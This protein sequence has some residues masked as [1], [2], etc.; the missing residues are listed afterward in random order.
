MHVIRRLRREADQG[1]TLIELLVVIVLLG[2]VGSIVMGSLM[3]AMKSTRQHQNR[4][5][6]TEDV[7]TQVE[8]M[9]R[10]IRVADP[11]RA[12]SA[13][14]MTVDLYRGTSCV[15]QQWSISG[16]TLQVTATTYSTWAA[17]SKYPA[18]VA[19]V[20]TTTRAALTDL[21]NPAATIFTYENSSGATLTNPAV[22][23][24]AVVHITLSKKVGE[25]STSVSFSTSVGVRNESL[26]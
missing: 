9:A 6:S 7:Q 10:D 14:S 2:V 15:R 5:Y 25:K 17:C 13:T 12:A 26:A 21:T 24:I 4:T 18:T 1:Y 22:S 20:S 11:I 19:A 8:R 16:T 3:L 23:Q